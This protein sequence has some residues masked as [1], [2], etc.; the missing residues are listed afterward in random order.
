MILEN[1]PR[2]M[3]RAKDVPMISRGWMVEFVSET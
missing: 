3:K 1:L 2:Y